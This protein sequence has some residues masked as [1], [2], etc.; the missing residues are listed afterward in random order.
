VSAR[1]LEER[2]PEYL[3]DLWP[4][5]C[6]LKP[7][8]REKIPEDGY[9]IESLTYEVEAGDRVPTLVLVPEGVDAANPAAAIAVWHQHK[10]Q[11]HFG[12]SEP[13]GLA[14]IRRTHILH[15]L[16]NFIPGWFQY[17]DTPDIAAPIAAR[18]LHLNLGEKDDRRNPNPKWHNI[19]PQLYNLHATPYERVMLGLFVIWQG[20][21]NSECGR[22]R[23]QK[24]NEVLLGF[25]RDGFHWSRPSRKAF[26][27]VNE[28]EG[29]WN[30]GNVQS[31]GGGC[32]V[33]GGRLFFYYSARAK[34][35]KEWDADA[36]TGLAFLRRDGFASMDADAR[37]GTLTT[38][39]VKFKGRFLFVN[40]DC[41]RGELRV[42]VLDP[43]GKP[44][45]PFTA[46][47]CVPLSCDRALA[48]V[49]WKGAED[50]SAVAGRPARFR[51]HL[52]AGRLYAFWVGP[53]KSSASHG[54][55]AAGGPGFTGPT[56]TVGAR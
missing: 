49:N 56:D 54:Y 8:L 37:G 35:K 7:V 32:L 53:D 21:N 46:E 27:E 10:G 29:A 5:P 3:A 22:L 50:L 18:A 4:E 16:P 45:P 43:D 19:Y 1:G 34:P 20:P 15:C 51:F 36:S 47:N 30:W 41:P 17:G 14:A 2:L 13:A 33:V 42:E 52:R 48:E 24:R 39:P 26:L 31:V 6:D 23:V 28:K 9:T 44:I 55:V 25:S 11:W 38:R 40:V 12:K